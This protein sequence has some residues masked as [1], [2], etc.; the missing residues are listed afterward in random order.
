[1]IQQKTKIGE[2][3]TCATCNKAI[4]Y[5]SAGWLHVRNPGKPHLGAPATQQTI[6]EDP[7]AKALERVVELENVVEVQGNRIQTLLTANRELSEKVR[8]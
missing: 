1:M 6:V 8:K 7:L 4:V 2:R 3:A 5:G